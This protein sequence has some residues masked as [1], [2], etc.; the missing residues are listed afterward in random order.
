[1]TPEQWQRIRPIL[2][3][4]LELDSANRAHFLD[5]ACEDSSL[6]REV[7][8]LIAV[9]EG[10]GTGV[11]KSPSVPDEVLDEEVHFRLA[12]GKRIGPYE[13]LG[14][15]AEGGMGAVY[16]A[17][18]ADGQYKQEVALKIV[19]AEF[20]GEATSARF[21]N[22]RQILANLDHPNIA[23]I[24][25]GGTTAEGV[26]YFAMELIGG[27]P[28]TKYC[29]QHKLT[30][31]QRL[32]LFR[33]VCSAVHYA[34]QHLVIHR[35]IKPTNI[36]VTSDG[37]P[38]L[39][40]FGI[41]KI[42]D[43]TMLPENRTLTVGGLS[44]MTPEYASP[45]Q[46]Q[47]APLTT[48]TDVYSLGLILYE[49]LA[50]RRPYRFAS[51]MPH[52]VA[53]AVL[54][55]DPEKPSTATL[56]EEP[57]EALTSATVTPQLI[58]DL[59][60]DSLVK[61]RR[62]LS[63]DLDNI[64]LKSLRKEPLARYSSADQ[65]SDDIRRHLEGLPVLARKGSVAYRAR[66]YVQRHKV[67]VGAAA[68]IAASLLT[69]MFLTLRE[70][71]IARANQLRAERRFNDV[72]ALANSLMF[73]VHDSIR[74]L[75]GA[76][77]ARKL[78]VSKALQYLD[79]LSTESSGDASLQRELAAA[80]ERVADVQGYP[81]SPNLGDLDGALASYRKALPMRESFV[82]HSHSS[83][84]QEA[85]AGDYERIGRVLMAE[86]KYSEALEF[87]RKHVLLREAL[88][89]SNQSVK[90]QELLAG[91]HF[92]IAGCYNH[93]GDS[94]KALENYRQSAAIREPI[95]A[96]S[97]NIQTRL[98]GT[99]GFMAGILWQTGD[100][101]Q[102]ILVEQKALEIMTKLSNSDPSNAVYRE[103]LDEA[104]YYAGF[105]QAEG[106]NFSQALV[107][108]RR[109]LND[110]QKL[111]AADPKEARAKEYLANSYKSVGKAL[112]GTGD[113]AGGLD[114][115]RKALATFQQLPYQDIDDLAETRE[116]MGVAYSRMASRPG[117]SRAESLADWTQ[118]R[119]AYQKS[120]DDWQF[121]MSRGESI[122][123]GTEA[124]N[125]LKS[126]LA[127]CDAAIQKKVKDGM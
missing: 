4:A 106:G 63:G 79:S 89:Q 116:G 34:H 81:D 41:A 52:D 92:L 6:R 109:A 104:Y 101:A 93:L 18:R 126:E 123:S 12:S 48:A 59:R 125:R 3:S 84:D 25:D 50:G 29:D 35:D 22:E 62:R 110:F 72:R 108:Y 54:E 21:R 88:A 33:T 98:A 118:S 107:S 7:E 15:I 57:A 1:M 13:I 58:S 20:G 75:A 49:L 45:E 46:L 40:D 47:G 112:V 8:S 73:E 115:L 67:V 124:V 90:S 117:I 96:Q 43:P 31:D 26:P 83:E 91:S 65:L 10:A 23:K 113:F 102:A 97:P 2:E 39:L 66:K 37:V 9:H 122:P 95:A 64:V 53:R 74:N 111:S 44:M 77:P 70:A 103:F 121:L 11:L 56:R 114:S 120:L 28:I 86:A 85:L 76:T 61:L 87:A 5:D 127:K 82:A 16:R 100:H 42:L 78:L 60:S 71:R 99:Y 36:L 80:Y 27:L 119:A 94:N 68:L 24:L 38:K 105:Y 19:R 69:G 32:T 17:V 51:K 30:V 55:N 14:E